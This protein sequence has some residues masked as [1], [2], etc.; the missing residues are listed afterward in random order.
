MTCNILNDLQL[1]HSFLASANTI[2][3]HFVFAEK[4][5]ATDATRGNNRQ[6][7]PLKAADKYMDLCHRG[8]G[9]ENHLTK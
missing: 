9:D 4:H 2:P 3:V 8:D 6:E 5:Q 1:R 7:G